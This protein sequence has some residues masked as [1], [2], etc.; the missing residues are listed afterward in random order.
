MEPRSTEAPMGKTPLPLTVFLW[1]WRG[2]RPVYD[3]RNVNAMVRML[4]AR[5]LMPHRVVCVTDMPHGI[6]CETVPLWEDK[7][8]VDGLKPKMPNS[9][10]RL[11]LFSA[12]MA[13]QF[14]GWALSLDLDAVL[15]K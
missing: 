14:P 1:L 3:Y 2:W 7:C 15:A 4:E 8:R 9:Y 12:E 11:R 10:R 13:E 5:L 6:D